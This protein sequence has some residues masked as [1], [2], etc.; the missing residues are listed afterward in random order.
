MAKNSKYFTYLGKLATF[1]KDIVKYDPS[2]QNLVFKIVGVKKDIGP[3]QLPFLVEFE[4]PIDN[5]THGASC[6]NN[7]EYWLYGSYNTYEW[8]ANTYNRPEIYRF[9]DYSEVQLFE[10]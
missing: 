1:P 3:F 9:L 8:L 6:V 2:L 7:R 4:R 5:F 10:N